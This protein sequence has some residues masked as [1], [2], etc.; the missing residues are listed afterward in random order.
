MIGRRVGLDALVGLIPVIGDGV[1]AAVAGWGVVIAARMGAPPVL[2]LR[3]LGNIGLDTLVGAVPLL[4]D[5]FDFGWHAQ[6]RNL[7]LLERWTEDPRAVR[8]SSRL[9]VGAVITAIV[10]SVVAVCWLAVVAVG[11]LLAR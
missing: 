6:T 10:G 4:G 7:R 9:M 8:R 5:L 11:W 1:G 3:M 2:L